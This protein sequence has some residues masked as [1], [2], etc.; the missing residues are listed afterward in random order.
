MSRP[1]FKAECTTPDHG[2]EH[3][4]K[5]GEFYEITD[6]QDAIF[7][8]DYYIIGKN[9]EGKG[10]SCHLYRFAITKEF[11]EDYVLQ[12][13]LDWRKAAVFPSKTYTEGEEH[14]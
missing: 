12:H 10:F 5:K 6:I 2:Y 13:H 7:A 1:K 9:N 4:L 14:A 8:G 11:A 3:I